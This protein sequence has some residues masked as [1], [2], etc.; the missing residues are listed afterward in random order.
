MISGQ[1]FKRE[2]A[3]NL[4]LN[5]LLERASFSL[6]VSNVIF[7]INKYRV[8]RFLEK[9]LTSFYIRYYKT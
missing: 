9:S 4:W 8:T 5:I 6:I 7:I 2:K 1:N 3:K